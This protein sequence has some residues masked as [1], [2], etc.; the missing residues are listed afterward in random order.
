M[1]VIHIVAAATLFGCGLLGWLINYGRSYATRLKGYSAE[2]DSIQKRINELEISM[3]ET[4]AL[5]IANFPKFSPPSSSECGFD[6]IDGVCTLKGN[7][8]VTGKFYAIQAN[9]TEDESK[10]ESD[11]PDFSISSSS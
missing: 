1:K 7:L 4:E 8:Q 9:G 6:M 3:K 11:A 5:M 2:I 10:S